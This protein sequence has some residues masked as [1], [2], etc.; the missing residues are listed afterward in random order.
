MDIGKTRFDICR[1]SAMSK[2]A[3]RDRFD[4]IGLSSS[5]PV[6]AC[7]THRE[8]NIRALAT[9]YVQEAGST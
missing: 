8:V 4:P 1:I 6:K 5:M 3:L 9:T 7:T 2:T